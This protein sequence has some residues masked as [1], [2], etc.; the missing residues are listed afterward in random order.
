M[1]NDKN[2]QPKLSKEEKSH[3][4]V[5]SLFPKIKKKKT[6]P[7]MEDVQRVHAAANEGLTTAQVTERIDQG[8]V[9]TSG[10]KQSK[11]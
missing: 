9:N 5:L 4:N 7:P 3:L 1:S 10:K 2:Q 11:T 8:L 6:T